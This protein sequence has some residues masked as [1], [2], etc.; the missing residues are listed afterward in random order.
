LGIIFIVVLLIGSASVIFD[1]SI[2]IKEFSVDDYGE[3]IVSFDNL[4]S[5]A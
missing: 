3:Y 4:G 5:L 2:K 1:N